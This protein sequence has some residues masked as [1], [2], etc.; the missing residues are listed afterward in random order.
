MACTCI[1]EEEEGEEEEEEE[2][3][4]SSSSISIKDGERE[5]LDVFPDHVYEV[6]TSRG[7]EE[8]DDDDPTDGRRK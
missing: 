8:D 7:E 3:A 2:D 4:A 6:R 5:E 1:F